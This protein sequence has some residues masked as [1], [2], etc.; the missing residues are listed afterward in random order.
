MGEDQTDDVVE[1]RKNRN[2]HWQHKRSGG[3]G[4]Q[5]LSWSISDLNQLPG[6]AR[7]LTCRNKCERVR[8]ASISSCSLS[9]GSDIVSVLCITVIR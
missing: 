3:A 4:L 7:S 8:N 6:P 2:R 9:S 1:L 5:R